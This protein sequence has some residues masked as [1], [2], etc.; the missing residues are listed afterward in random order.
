LVTAS[1]AEGHNIAVIVDNRKRVR[2]REAIGLVL[3]GLL[4]LVI[5]IA[6]YHRVVDWHVR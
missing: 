2:V 6:R 5:S 4:I 1:T 3:I